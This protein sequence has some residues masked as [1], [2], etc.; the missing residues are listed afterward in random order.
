M[1]HDC[2]YPGCEEWAEWVEDPA[3][4]DLWGDPAMI[5]SCPEHLELRR[6]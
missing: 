5:K 3:Q 2:Y 1:D 4:T 6:K